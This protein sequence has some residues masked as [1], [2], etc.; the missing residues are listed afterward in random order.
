MIDVH[1]NENDP[2][3]VWKFKGVLFQAVY[4][5]LLKVDMCCRYYEEEDVN[6]KMPFV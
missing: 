6:V 3:G 4:I 1:V 5:Y 2:R